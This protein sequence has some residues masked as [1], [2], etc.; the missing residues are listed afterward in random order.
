MSALL[1]EPVYRGISDF[2]EGEYDIA[3]AV[4]RELGAHVGTAGQAN[5]ILIKDIDPEIMKEQ[6]TVASRGEEKNR[7]KR[8]PRLLRTK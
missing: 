2:N 5:T 8:N 6:F 3:F 4:P 1:K 7:I